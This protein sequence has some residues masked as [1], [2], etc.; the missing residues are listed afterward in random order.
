MY[1][2]IIHN[3]SQHIGRVSP[4]LKVPRINYGYLKD[5][6]LSR[7]FR[8]H[9]PPTFPHEICYCLNVST[10]LGRVNTTALQEKLFFKVAIANHEDPN[11]ELKWNPLMKIL[12]EEED[13]EH[14]SAIKG[15]FHLLE[16]AEEITYVGTSWSRMHLTRPAMTPMTARRYIGI[17]ENIK[18][19]VINSEGIK[20]ED[21]LEMQWACNPHSIKIRF[22]FPF[23]FTDFRFGAFKETSKD[24]MVE[25][26][27][28]FAGE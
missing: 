11:I 17:H 20:L 8:N 19:G 13:Q 10:R 28:E 26:G 3:R 9:F 24:V 12:M 27:A 6:R 25:A 22:N 15:H 4:S 16:K 2:S 21:L 23:V 7:D 14:Y 5:L 18:G 1:V